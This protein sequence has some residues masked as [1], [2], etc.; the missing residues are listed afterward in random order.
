MH[1][2]PHGFEIHIVN[3]KI[4]RTIEQNF[5][6]FPDKLNFTNVPLQTNFFITFL[7][8]EKDNNK[9]LFLKNNGKSQKYV[10][11]ANS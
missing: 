5:V 2:H 11:K 6:A 7:G 9:S 8:N 4:I 3:V 1:N 10:I